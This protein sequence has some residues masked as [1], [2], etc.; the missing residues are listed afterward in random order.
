MT[1]I[2]ELY[3]NE[4]KASWAGGASQTIQL[5]AERTSF[6]CSIMSKRSNGRDYEISL[7]SELV[8]ENA[9]DEA[10]PILVEGNTDYRSQVGAV[11]TTG[12]GTG[13]CRFSRSEKGQ[14]WQK[15]FLTGRSQMELAYLTR[16]KQKS[17]VAFSIK[18][19]PHG[20]TGVKKMS[21]Q[22]TIP[23]EI[24]A[25]EVRKAVRNQLDEEPLNLPYL[26]DNETREFS[27]LKALNAEIHNDWSN[28]SFEKEMI[29]EERRNYPNAKGLTIPHSALAT[30]TTMLTSGDVGG[31]IGTQ[32]RPDLFIDVMRPVSSVVAAGATVLNLTSKTQVPKNS[33]DVSAAFT[34]EGASIS[35]S[36]L[37]IDTLTLEPKLLAGRSSYSR[38][39]LSL[40]TPEIENLVRRNL[41]LQVANGIDSAALTGSGSGANPT[42]IANTSNIETF[43]TASGNTMTHAESLDAVAEVAG[44]NFDTSQGTWLLNPTDA[45]TLGAQTKDSGS[46]Q[47]VYQDGR[48]L[49]RPVIES[50]HVTLNTAFFGL[51]EHCMIANFGAADIV[52][53]P[54]S[55]G[56]TGTIH[57]YI[58]QLVDV[59]VSQPG[60]FSKITLTT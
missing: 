56:S 31:G 11:F 50:T 1:S 16:N 3:A 18:A 40:V 5:D 42:G 53:D 54:Y 25:D 27:L 21:E 6:E 44:N 20:K 29:A 23:K 43:A 30:R 41:Q 22:I 38:A 33:N 36:D 4:P 47:F 8:S 49:G 39:V 57:V 9:S 52:V 35:E 51:F 28:A 45:A 34:A 58:Y 48:I 32:H 37:D 17:P 55:G 13:I 26:S 19:V 59:A 2:E 60:A 12:K 15:S 14:E 10:Y 7:P 24:I 46:G